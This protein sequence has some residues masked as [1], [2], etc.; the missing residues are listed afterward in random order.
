MLWRLSGSRETDG[1]PAEA[2]A[3]GTR[4]VAALVSSIAALSLVATA[5]CG[6]FGGG[7][8]APPPD[9]TDDSFKLVLQATPQLNNCGS[10]APNALAVRVY[11]LAGDVAIRGASLSQLWDREADELGDEMLELNEVVLDPG[12][13]S[14]VTVLQKTKARFLAVAGSF[15][16]PEGSCWLW[17]V[18]FSK[19]KDG[20]ILNFAET[21]ILEAK[22]KPKGTN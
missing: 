19:L 5:G 18:P 9:V 2:R 15:C 8:Q 3:H 16:E 14:T 17:V 1:R 22:A 6:I 13:K 12:K 20:Q 10:G 11:Q 7:K 4:V 21:C